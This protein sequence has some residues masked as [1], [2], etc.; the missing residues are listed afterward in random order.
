MP[1]RCPPSVASAPSP[2]TQREGTAT[3]W[4]LEVG[5]VSQPPTPR[6]RL[7]PCW[8]PT[9]RQITDHPQHGGASG[10]HLT[11]TPG[12]GQAPAEFRPQHLGDPPTDP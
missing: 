2:P 10:G 5:D 3:W 6:G 7:P 8:P 1:T 11:P 4:V 12:P 9:F